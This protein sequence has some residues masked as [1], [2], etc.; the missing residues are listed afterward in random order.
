MIVINVVVQEGTREAAAIGIRIT[1]VIPTGG[2]RIKK[3]IIINR[4]PLT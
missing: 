1:K 4:T 2:I 3:G